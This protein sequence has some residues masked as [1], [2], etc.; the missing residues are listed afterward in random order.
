MSCRS[1]PLGTRILQQLEVTRT[2]YSL[3]V[4]PSAIISG[5]CSHQCSQCRTLRD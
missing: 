1:R 4:Y 5:T 2:I 3:P